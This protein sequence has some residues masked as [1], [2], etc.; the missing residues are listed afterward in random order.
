MALT[1]YLIA[2]VVIGAMTFSLQTSLYYSYE[3]VFLLLIGDTTLILVLSLLLT[4]TLEMT[5]AEAQKEIEY[6]AF[7]MINRESVVGVED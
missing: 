3:G 2:P 7:G 4:S 6:K 1:I 5:C